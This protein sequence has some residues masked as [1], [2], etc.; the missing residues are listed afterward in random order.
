MKNTKSTIVSLLIIF[1]LSIN[2]NLKAQAPDKTNYVI[3]LDLSDRILSPNQA[4]IDKAAILDIYSQFVKDVKNQLIIKSNAKFSIHILP[5]QNSKLDTYFYNELLSIDISQFSMGN[6]RKELD[7]FSDK[8]EPL[9]SRLYLEAKYSSKSS[10]YNG[11]DI[12]KFFNESLSYNLFNDYRNTVV[13]IT[14]GYFD[15]ESNSFVKQIGNRYTST[16]FLSRLKTNNWKS[17]A[18]N[19]DYGLLKIQNSFPSTKVLVVG[20]NPKSQSLDEREKIHYFWTKWV[21]EMNMG[22]AIIDKS[23]TLQI[24]Q[25]LVL[26]IK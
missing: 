17:I 15:F 4:D 16:R 8:I 14:D 2:F 19:K 11:V 20:V 24:K 9:L 21:R 13:V 26:A 5:Q 6:K 10:D 23:S 7:K 3:V 18:R 25:Q 12:W 1:L 22:I